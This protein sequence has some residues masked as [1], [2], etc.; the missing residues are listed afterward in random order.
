M[1]KGRR[2]AKRPPTVQT[3]ARPAA[4]YQL[5]SFSSEDIVR[6]NA[7]SIKFDELHQVL[8]F[9]LERQRLAHR[10]ALLSA[11]RSRPAAPFKLAPWYR[12]V[13]YRYCL[14]PLSSVGS[15]LRIGGR[16]NFGKE[17]RDGYFESFPALYV[18]E[19]VETAYREFY[20]IEDKGGTGGLSSRD[21]ALR[22]PGGFLTAEIHGQLGLVFDAGDLKALAPFA[23]VV[24]QFKMPRRATQIIRELKLQDWKLARTANDVRRQLLL[25]TWREEPRQF[26]LPANSQI[27]GRLLR[28]AGF[29]AVLYPSSKN[30]ARCLA[31]F[32]ENLREA[33]S[34]LALSGAYPEEVQVRRIDSTTVRSS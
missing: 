23:A 27:L 29:E 4:L 14:E 6:W 16:F 34:F 21:L 33:D 19:T 13:E 7:A 1:S 5:E 22:R 11:L 2:P 12:V 9:D 20:Q 17:I 32:P 24:S 28:D 15:T 8:Y 3:G 10:E 26:D 18:A 25:P 31:V 30:A